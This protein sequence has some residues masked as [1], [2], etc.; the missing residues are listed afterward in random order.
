MNPAWIH[1]FKSLYYLKIALLPGFAVVGYF[2]VT[3]GWRWLD[4]EQAVTNAALGLP[5]VPPLAAVFS[6]TVMIFSSVLYFVILN[7]ARAP[8]NAVALVLGVLQL[9]VLLILCRYLF[10]GEFGFWRSSVTALLLEMNALLLAVVAVKWIAKGTISGSGLGA[11]ST[12]TILTGYLVASLLLLNATT[13]GRLFWQDVLSLGLVGRCVLGGAALLAVWGY[14]RSFREIGTE[15]GEAARILGAETVSGIVL[16]PTWGML[17]FVY[18]LCP[19]VR[20]VIA[21]VEAMRK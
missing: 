18:P 5:A 1:A 3:T 17:I 7:L 8:A 10:G 14:C 4:E 13:Y 15:G 21:A 20:I 16:V 11:S 2:I 6:A 9:P 19:V 12:E